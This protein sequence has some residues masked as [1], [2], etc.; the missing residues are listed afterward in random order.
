MYNDPTS[1]ETLGRAQTAG[2]L[3][4]ATAAGGEL[5]GFALVTE[6]EGN[7]HL[8]ELDVLPAHGGG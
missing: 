6:R 2:R 4:V 3:W 1:V 8:D 5:A 7:A